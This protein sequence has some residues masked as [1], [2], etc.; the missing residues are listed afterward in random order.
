MRKS[1]LLFLLTAFALAYVAGC[2][3]SSPVAPPPP[4]QAA[5]MSVSMTDAPPA[6]VTVLSFEVSVSGASLLPGSVDLLAGKTPPRIEVKKLETESAFLST[7]SIPAGTYTSL[8]LTFANP[9]VTFLNN[10]GATLAGCANGAICEIKPAGTLSATVNGNFAVTAGMQSG[11]LVDVNLASL[12]SNSMGVDFSAA[13]AVTA[14][15]QTQRAKGELEDLDD[16]D[17]ILKSPANNQFTLQTG[18]M[19]NITV[20]TDSS[21]EF[22]DFAGCAAANFSCLVDG[23]S[24]EVDLM[25]LG[26]GS[27]LAKK[28]ELH[29]SVAEAAD[30]EVDG[31][32]SKIDSATQFE[33]VVI[34]ELRN[35]ANVSVGNPIIVTLQANPSFRVDANGL[36]V[37]SSLGAAFTAAGDTSQLLPGQTVQV[38]VRSTSG[39]P[40]PA[41]ITVAT[42][43]VRLRM[44]RFTATV[45]GAVSGSNFNVGSLPGIFTANGVNLI[46]VQTSSSTNFENTT[47]TSGLA[48]GNTVSL[49]GLLFVSAPNPVLIADKVRK[50]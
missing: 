47:G 9:E 36:Q 6:G 5:Q 39:G 34:D 49:R 22:G 2:S 23:Q 29:D 33:V 18:D 17:G 12:I 50:R 21:T 27:F 8:N 44:T 43:R 1:L 10:T 32:V 15:Q 3:G 28:V 41:P 30:D 13:G 46:Q 20:T 14:T 24:V 31:V 42:D 4:A 40:A 37:P 35:I 19:G 25:V 38:R 7:L 11:L 45:S 48:S 26:T 16:V